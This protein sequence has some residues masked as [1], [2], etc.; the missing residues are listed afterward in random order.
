[1]LWSVTLPLDKSVCVRVDG[2]ERAGDR[3]VTGGADQLPAR[4]PAGTSAPAPAGRPLLGGVGARSPG[5]R[6]R[7]RRR[8]SPP[9]PGRW[10]SGGAPAA[11]PRRVP[12]TGWGLTCHARPPSPGPSRHHKDSRAGGKV[13]SP[14]TS[15]A[16]PA[17]ASEGRAPRSPVPLCGGGGGWPRLPSAARSR[18]SGKLSRAMAPGQPSCWPVPSRDSQASEPPPSGRGVGGAPGGEQDTPL[19]PSP[20]RRSPPRHAGSASP[21]AG[22]VR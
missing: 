10:T 16:A 13:A 4:Y 3:S 15:S 14:S 20:P 22:E 18:R 5:Q 19:P 6:L 9:R 17:G 8:R 11:L 1:M 21:T 2:E 12:S 7:S